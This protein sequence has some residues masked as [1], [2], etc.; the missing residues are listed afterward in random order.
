MCDTKPLA[1]PLTKEQIAQQMRDT[2]SV[3]GIVALEIGDIIDYD[4]ESFLDLLSEQLIGND[5]LMDFG[6][7]MIGANMET[8]EIYFEVS[9]SY[10]TGYSDWVERNLEGNEEIQDE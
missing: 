9:G 2:G 6:Y 5:L 3:T 7:K 8:Q 4:F 1:E 10:D